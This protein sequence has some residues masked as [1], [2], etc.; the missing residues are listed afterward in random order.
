MPAVS[1][2]TTRL[3]VKPTAG[4]PEDARTLARANL[5]DLKR[6]I[7]A[8]LG[9][10]RMNYTT[11]AHLEETAARINRALEAQWQVPVE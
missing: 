2:K 4:T 7:E 1:P 5:V 8:R 11:R 9:G 10:G 6:K 3:V